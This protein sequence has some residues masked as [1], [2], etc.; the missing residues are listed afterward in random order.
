MFRNPEIEKFTLGVLH[1]VIVKKG[2]L[3]FSVSSKLPFVA[4]MMAEPCPPS[5][6][7][8]APSPLRRPLPLCP[9][10]TGTPP[11]HPNDSALL[12]CQP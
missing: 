7:I 5:L 12:L 2:L 3:L 1:L 9:S 8:P 11:P 10:Q 6:L 4:R